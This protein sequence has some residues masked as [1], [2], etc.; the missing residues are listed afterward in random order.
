MTSLGLDAF[1]ATE[2]DA[3]AHPEC[4]E[5]GSVFF[6]YCPFGGGR[7][8]TL[9]ER[10]EQVALRRTIRICCVDLPL[11]KVPW[12]APIMPADVSFDV[13]RSVTSTAAV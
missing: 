6:M 13:Y 1:S 8:A 12:L 11:P 5:R 2:G 10:L 7:L 9:L 4:L 3:L